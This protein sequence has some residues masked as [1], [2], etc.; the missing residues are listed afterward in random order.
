MYP[1]IEDE[2]LVSEFFCSKNSKGCIIELNKQE[3]YILLEDL[4]S[5]KVIK[6]ECGTGLAKSLSNF[7]LPMYVSYD[8]KIKLIVNP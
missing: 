3:D 5:K 1:N 4:D 2:K 7:D 6:I 8:E